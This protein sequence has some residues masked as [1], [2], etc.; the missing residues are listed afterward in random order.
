MKPSCTAAIL[1]ILQG[2]HTNP[3]DGID[4]VDLVGKAYAMAPNAFPSHPTGGTPASIMTQ[5]YRE[6][7][8][9]HRT[10]IGGRYI[11][12][13]DKNVKMPKVIER[14]N[15]TPRATRVISSR[16]KAVATSEQGEFQIV[17]HVDGS[18]A[19]VVHDGTLYMTIEDFARALN[20]LRGS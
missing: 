16:K 11:Y 6:N 4:A 14:S 18:A 10:K 8:H 13:F 5:V 9:V 1:A 12:Y 19:G 17:K 3:V 20:K 15:R 7:K 2:H